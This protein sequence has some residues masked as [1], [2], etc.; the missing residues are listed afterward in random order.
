MQQSKACTKCK[1]IKS[2]SNFGKHKAGKD[3]LRAR[4][5]PCEGDDHRAYR[6]V[7]RDKVRAAKRAWDK[8]NK[9]KKAAWDK[10]YAERNKDKIRK[11]FIAWYEINREDQLNKNKI[12]RQLNPE[13]KAASDKKW[14]SEN[15]HKVN[16]NS[17]AWRTR[18]PEKAAEVAKS[19]RTRNPENGIIKSARRRARKAANGTFLVTTKDLKKIMSK[20]CF[21]CQ[22][23]ATHL[24]H[25]LP[26][27]LGGRHSIGNL[28]ASCRACNL[29]KHKKTIME[30]RVYKQKMLQFNQGAGIDSTSGKADEESDLD[31]GANPHSSTLG[32]TSGAKVK[33]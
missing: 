33:L 6:K 15:K 7:N 27:V 16:A 10:S 11:N 19:Y 12:R 32:Y 14:Q 8:K 26:I 1:E 28:V 3:G 29:S 20:P 24:E 21:Y 31:W 22:G 9:D 23:P 25:V 4:C 18:N 30:W 2:L 5:K 13:K 17:K